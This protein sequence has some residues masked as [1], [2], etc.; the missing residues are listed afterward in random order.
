MSTEIPLP[1]TG[2]NRV[3]PDTAEQFGRYRVLR[4]IGQGSSATV[5]EALDTRMERRVALKVLQFDPALPLDRRAAQIERFERE[6]RAIA[7]LSHPNIVQVFDVSEEGGRHFLVMELLDGINLRERLALGGP[8]APAEAVSIVT[9][10]ASALDAT[11]AQGIVHRD[12]KPSNVILLPDGRVKMLDFGI[13][14][15]GED[16][17]VTQVGMVVGSPAYMAPEQGRGEPTTPASDIWSL[18]ALVYEMLAGRPPFAGPH[19]AAIL[20]KAS[21]D[22]PEPL[23]GDAAAAQPVI[24]RGLA[25]TPSDRYRTA[26]ELAADLRS[27][28]R[29]DAGA[30]VSA[31]ASPVAVAVPSQQRTLKEATASAFS[32]TTPRRTGM[33]VRSEATPPPAATPL[34]D[35]RR[36]A[37][38]RPFSDAAI[39]A[40]WSAL[41]IVGIGILALR[42]R[43]VAAPPQTASAI[44]ETAASPSP[45]VALTPG[46]PSPSPLSASPGSVTAAAASPAPPS[47]SA[48]PS[49]AAVVSASPAP[50]PSVAIAPPPAGVTVVERKPSHRPAAPVVH[51]PPQPA[52][53]IAA[54]APRSA[55]RPAAPPAPVVRPT[56]KLVAMTHPVV[57]KAPLPAHERAAESGSS[58]VPAPEPSWDSS[59]DTLGQPVP[60]EK[61]RGKAARHA[62][63]PTPTPEVA[64]ESSSHDSDTSGGAYNPQLLRG[65]W[66][67]NIRKQEATLIVDQTSTETFSGSVIVRTDSGP[68]RYAVSG[69]F[70]ADTGKLSFWPTQ[71]LEGTP[72]PGFDIGQENG[73]M[74]SHK[75]MG[76]LSVVSGSGALQVFTWSLSR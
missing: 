75:D 6:A 36:G 54:A 24:A 59:Q 76:G 17:T 30:A 66:H 20:Y 61:K 4:E 51:T 13:A 62:P 63:K 43:P 56:P 29:T 44:G 67:G 34:L 70:S 32:P 42:L 25:K 37:A 55:P 50:K 23:T 60:V 26:G 48:V 2:S 68:I 39:L 11:H 35:E 45:S 14:R 1:E 19:V 52:A 3:G 46:A 7:R 71:T 49:S 58:G 15:R 5:Y 40:A 10:I 27:A 64:S 47:P 53:Q 33:S 73:R 41:G 38:R 69:T 8:L 22:Q 21:Y 12:I 57:P 28:F 65:R 74:T 31:A 9:Q 72:P 16:A 18:S